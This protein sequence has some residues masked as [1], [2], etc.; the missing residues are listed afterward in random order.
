MSL[1]FRR[2]KN[3][4]QNNGVPQIIRIG[5]ELAD[6]RRGGGGDNPLLLVGLLDLVVD[7]DRERS[8]G[9]EHPGEVLSAG[10]D[11]GRWEQRRTI[12]Q[13][14]APLVELAVEVELV[15]AMA[16]RMSVSACTLRSL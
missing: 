12:H 5:E 8:Q 1:P 13:A 6:A 11:R 10:E 14:L 7:P 4:L 3:F 15:C 2:A 9:D 16:R